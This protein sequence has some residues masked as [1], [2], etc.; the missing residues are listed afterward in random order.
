MLAGGVVL[1]LISLY[2]GLD[3][4][5]QRRAA[6]SEAKEA[7][8]QQVVDTAKGLDEELD[9][10]AKLADE[11]A[12]AIGTERLSAQELT[13][14]LKRD[15][16]ANPNLHS[17]GAAYAPSAQ[18]EGRR[19]FAPYWERR[20]GELHLLQLED[21]LGTTGADNTWFVEAMAGEA[22]WREPV[23]DASRQAVTATYSTPFPGAEKGSG[24]DAAGVVW[25][26]FSMES[27]GER[28]QALDLGPTGYAGIVSK[29]G[30]PLAYPSAAMVRNRVSFFDLPE[31]RSD[32]SFL[33][34]VESATRGERGSTERDNRLTGQASWVFW[35]PVDESGWSTFV[36]LIKDEIPVDHKAL[37]RR[38]IWIIVSTV[39]GLIG[40][41]GWACIRARQRRPGNAMLWGLVALSTILMMTGMFSIRQ[42]V[43]RQPI[44]DDADRVTIVDRSGLDAFLT[45]QSAGWSGESSLQYLPIGIYLQSMKFV[46]PQEV[47]VTGYVWQKNGVS[48]PTDG[49]P[50]FVL[51]DA[52]NP[53]ITEAYRYEDNGV[54][55]MGWH[56]ETTIRQN[57]NLSRYPLDDAEVCIRFQPRGLDQRLVLVPDLGSYTLTHPAARPGLDKKLLV[58]G[59]KVVGSLFDYKFESYDSSLGIPGRSSEAVVP[60]LNFNVRIRRSFLDVIIGNGIPLIGVLVMLFAMVASS[61][62]DEEESKLL[63]FNPSGVMKV[64]SALFFIVLLAHVQLRSTIQVQQVVFMEYIFFVVYSAILLVSLHNFLFSLERYNKGRLGYRNGLVQKLLFW[65][66]LSAALLLVMIFQFY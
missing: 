59:W 25:L 39:F 63:G 45:T 15:L 51:P 44:K 57:L 64:G 2:L 16:E 41:A 32:P 9:H 26:S 31:V 50:G 28:L 27:V 35:E 12:S 38:I 14:R 48:E 34:V 4:A 60:E 22:G 62:R 11:L 54:E 36:V 49:E 58:A 42:V 18:I 53:R 5:Y 33:A 37:R 10:Y 6:V 23:W 55:T 17:I 40:V 20:E 19:L 1:L 43:F 21:S 30:Y 66:L 56:I 52:S 47:F 13:P 61:T 24:K 65:P 3:L 46:A 29:K 8:R 7:A